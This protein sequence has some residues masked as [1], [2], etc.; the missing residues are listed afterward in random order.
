MDSWVKNTCALVP[1]IFDMVAA[2]AKPISESEIGDFRFSYYEWNFSIGNL[3]DV[4]PM[5]FSVGK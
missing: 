2:L 1:D 3:R 4:I 5:V